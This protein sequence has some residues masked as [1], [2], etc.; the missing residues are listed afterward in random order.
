[1]NKYQL[2]FLTFL[3]FILSISLITAEP[4]PPN[5]RLTNNPQLNNE[6]Q[7]WICPT[8]SNIVIANWRDFRL[9]YRQVGIGRSTDGG[10][11]WSDS[12]VNHA[13]QYFGM[14]A[15]QSDPTLT[16][17]QYGNFYMS[18]LDYDGFGFTNG[19]I[20]AFYKSTDKGL[21]WT[22][23]VS[24]PNTPDYSLNY[25]EDKQFI[26]VDRTGGLYDGHIYC[27]WTRFPN[28]D[29]IVVVRS[30]NG[31]ASFEDTVVVGP[32]Q[33]STGCGASQIDAGQ[34]S[35]PVVNSNG[36][37][38]VFWLG[39]ALD[40]AATCTG[41]Q[42]IKH[43]ASSDGGAT[44]SYEDTITTVSG[45][46]T[47][48]GGINTNSLPVVDA[49]ITGGPFDGNMYLTFANTGSEDINFKS[50]IDFMKSTDNGVS[51][52]NRIQIN[53]DAHSGDFDSFHPWLICNQEG[54]ISVIFYDQRFDAPSYFLFDLMAAYSFDG[55]ETF[56]TNHRISSVSSNPGS[57]NR[58]TFLKPWVE[59]YDGSKT[60]ISQAQMAGLIGEYISITGFHDKMVAVW[61][62]SRD[63]NSE[64]YSANWYLPMLEPKLILPDIDESF[65]DTAIVTFNWATSW[66]HNEDRYRLEY[67]FDSTFGS[68]VTT[69]MT[70]TNFVDQ[71]LAIGNYYWRVKTFNTSETD[72]SDYSSVHSFTVSEIPCCVGIRGNV[73][74]DAGELIDISDLVSLVDFM[75]NSG[76]APICT[77]EANIDGDAGELIDI[78]DLVLLVD[79]MFNGGS[80]PAVCP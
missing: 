60:P 1:M 11:T 40:S 63:G 33:T 47:A 42:T 8:D 57:L 20:I 65:F 61:T 36:D 59:N 9:G 71:S 16:A 77:D 22:G 53:D 78:S 32:I 30:I 34:L 27:S 19:S 24:V 43:V 26:T 39:F 69:I 66:K 80:P 55:G 74:S 41:V 75:F 54:I 72:S 67:S 49:D 31:M 21:S 5:V 10:L 76:S 15:K 48:N 37:V 73:D 6:E 3:I 4:I 14:D 44:F 46:M 68:A 70:D 45:Y 13:M 51:W 7:A 25:F 18:N 58:S 62:D 50:D 28:P 35:I 2:S 52:S 23:P 79:F 12:L 56:T 38:H 17:D 29:R 64:V